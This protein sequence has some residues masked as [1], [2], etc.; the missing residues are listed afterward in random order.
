MK[1]HY[2]F[3]LFILMSCGKD[4]SEKLNLGYHYFPINEGLYKVY[5]V[6][7]IVHD[8][9]A[10]VHDSAY[11]QIKEVIGETYIDEEEEEAQKLYRYFRQDS[12]D[13]WTIKDVWVMKRT[14][15][16]AEVVEEN[17]RMLKMGFAISYNQYWDANVH[18]NFDKVE[19]YY[20]NIAKPF[21]ADDFTVFDSTATVEYKNLVTFIDYER[22][23][24]VY[25][26]N[27]GKIYSVDKYFTIE[28]GDT[29]QPIKGTELKYSIVEFG[30]E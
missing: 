3:I 23:F 1:L 30:N 26:A 10:G 27:V 16:T 25:A 28:N 5:D 22:K 19:C 11:Y 21:T 12:T 7:Q 8:D 14:L 9:E 15:T 6:S 24:E 4:N 13:N 18:N 20:E 2:I 29:L 17:Q